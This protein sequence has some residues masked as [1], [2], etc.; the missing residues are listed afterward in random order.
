MKNII[1]MLVQTFL[2]KKKNAFD[3]LDNGLTESVPPELGNSMGS[4]STLLLNF[5]NHHHVI[6]SDAM[7]G[8]AVDGQF[9]QWHYT[10]SLLL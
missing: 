2:F 1:E 3:L 10:M 4:S 9:F 7:H 6:D 5:R 8:G